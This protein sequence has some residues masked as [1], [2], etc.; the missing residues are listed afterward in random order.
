[1][2]LNDVKS[3]IDS[4]FDGVQPEELLHTLSKFGMKEYDFKDNDN[5]PDERIVG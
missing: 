3:K 4:Y 1:M 2:K 5:I